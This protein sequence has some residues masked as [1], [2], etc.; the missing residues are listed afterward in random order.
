VTQQARNLLINLEDHADSVKSLI[1]DR[2]AKFTAF[3]AVLTAA[4]IRIIGTPVRA[5]RANAIAERWISGARRECPDRMLITGG[6]HLRLVPGEYAGHY[7]AR[8]P[9]RALQQHPP[10]GRLLQPF[11]CLPGDSR[12]QLKV[13]VEVQDGELRAFGCRRDQQV[14]DRRRAV[15]SLPGQCAQDFDGAFLGRGR[16]VLDG[17]HRDGRE[18]ELIGHV[19]S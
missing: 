14:R 15:V 16:Q 17:H 18:T 7:N 1:R 5:P 3:D 10:A 19:I 4:G 8:R 6:R 11:D 12:D 13:L 2:D 9:H